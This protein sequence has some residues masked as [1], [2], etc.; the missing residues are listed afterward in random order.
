[1]KRLAR[2]LLALLILAGLWLALKPTLGHRRIPFLPLQWSQYLDLVDF[3]FNFGA[4]MILAVVAWLAISPAK[5]LRHAAAT[6]GNDE[7]G[8]TR[9]TSPQFH[10]SQ[11]ARH[12]VAADVRRSIAVPP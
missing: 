12:G 2:I 9:W 6:A 5:H 10:Q 7:E 11:V 1:M 4:F 8:T 3:W